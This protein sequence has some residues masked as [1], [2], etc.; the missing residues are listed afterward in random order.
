M[1]FSKAPLIDLE[2][3]LTEKNGKLYLN[4]VLMD[5]NK[6]QDL[7][8]EV[9]MFKNT[10]LWG[11]ITNTLEQQAYEAGWTRAKTLDDL[12]NG[13]AICYTI[14]TQKRIIEKISNAH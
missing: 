8:Q 11:I 6:V 7:K 1:I 3:V 13:K 12:M 10:S 9:H 2:K 4:N 5:A 14:E